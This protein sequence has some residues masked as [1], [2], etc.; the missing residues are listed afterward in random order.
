M[1]GSQLK[2]LKASLREQGVIGPQQS[3]KQKRRHAEEQKGRNDKR[4]QRGA[5]LSGIR[6]QFNPFDLKH[7]ARGPKFDVTSNV[8]KSAS[9]AKGIQGRPGAAKA[10]SEE[11]RRE[12]LL[13]DMQR[14]NKVGGILDRRFGENDPTMAPED[15]MLERFAHEKQ[16]A[17]KKNSMFDL[18]DDGPIS[19]LTH[20][21]KSISFDD[22]DDG[23]V[24]ADDFEERDLDAEDSDGSVRERQRLKRLRGLAGEANSDTS[25]KE[26]DRKK[27]KKEVMEE[28]IAKS[29][30]HKYERQ[31]AK[32][33]DD[34]MRVRIDKELSNIQ[35]LLSSS[36]KSKR[37][38]GVAAVSAIAGVERGEFDSNFDMQVKRLA[39]DRRAQP[40][41]RT[42]T[43]EEKLEEESKRLRELEEKRQK[44][45]RGEEVSDDN[46]S[47]D[48]RGKKI[49]TDD[50]ENADDDFGLG[51]GIRTRAT[52]TDLGLDDE[53]DFL[54]EDDLVASGSDLDLDL[55]DSG[56]ES[57]DESGDSD[58]GGQ[59]EDDEFTK[60]ILDEEESRNPVFRAV[61]DSNNAALARGDEHGLPFTFPCP[62]TL[63]EL[64]AITSQYPHENTPKIIQRV[65]ALYH[66]KLD[67]KNKERLGNFSMALV[68]Y[69]A[70]PWDPATAPPSSVVESVIRHI[71]SLAKM[72]PIEISNRFRHHLRDIAEGRTLTLEPSDLLLLS[73]IGSIF[74]TSDH[75]HQ[76]V[77][78]AML[79]IGRYLGQKVPTQLADFATG[80][81]LCVLSLQ[82][83]QLAKRYV[84]EVINFAVNT[85]CALAPTA[86][87]S[88]HITTTIPI[89]EN[90]QKRF[91]TATTEVRKLCFPDCI[92]GEAGHPGPDGEAAKISAA[93]LATTLQVLDAAADLW[94][95]KSAFIETFAPALRASQYLSAPKSRSRLPPSVAQLADKLSTKLERMSRLA[96]IAR[97]PLELHHHRRL[98]IKSFIPKFEE[99][100]DPDKHYDHDRE[101]AEL[102]KLQKE[103]KRERKGAMRELRKDANFMAREK[104]RTKIAKD[105]AYEKKFKRLVSEIQSEEGRES[106]AYERE[107]SARKRD[108]NK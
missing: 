71:H 80:T 33:D 54:I 45:M 23:N 59:I 50:D 34:E 19:G 93:A 14:R 48:N 8:P 63:H 74:P 98:A 83:Q 51:E 21:G 24:L 12:T 20:G 22:D 30:M 43:E 46:E 100:F 90:S 6:E 61:S 105:E 4:L 26:P 7:A 16:R 108:R 36:A 52:A 97:R 95:G 84:P 27:S 55:V 11:R 5:V 106:N 91:I 58:G 29:K 53:D 78:P 39:Q 101:R 67:A 82:Y 60:G 77:T 81:F 41:D 32:E 44:R 47:D 2:R 65:R 18:E 10:A 99:T 62:E 17:H 25:D 38:E 103:H 79:T 1:A 31:A 85:L 88:I 76:V 73:A 72:F 89:H 37:L 68:D 69:V 56:D 96:Q 40:Q 94:T 15:K 13:V 102:A 87:A 42:K 28:V 75:F 64:Q 104:L 86:P 35:M 49:A 107:K 70:A 92:P 3:K 66:P 57:D 9:A